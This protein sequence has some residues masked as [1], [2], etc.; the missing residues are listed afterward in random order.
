MNAEIITIG[1]ELLLG[2]VI[3]TNSA[4]MGLQLADIGIS[5]DRR[6]AIGDSESA[7][8]SAIAEARTRC[9]LILLTGGL[10][11][12]RDDI[13]KKTLCTYFNCGLR[14]DEEVMRHLEAIFEKRGRRMLEIN[15]QQADMPEKCTTLFNAV[16]TAPGMRFEEGEFTLIS[17]PGVPSEMMHILSTHVF[18]WLPE[19]YELPAIVH[20]TLLTAGIPESLLSEKLTTVE[21]QLPVNFKLAYLPA[22]NSIRLRL[23]GIGK[24]KD[25]VEKELLPILETIKSICA[26]NLVADYDTDMAGALAQK[27]LQ[28]NTTISLAESCT[29]GYIANAL[30]KQSGI[31]AVMKGAIVSYSN[32]IKHNELGVPQEI[33]TTEGAVSESCAKAMVEGILRKFDTDVA[34]STT[35]IAGPGGATEDKPV[36]LVFIGV[37]NKHQTIVKRFVFNGNREQ[38]MQRTCTAALQML[39]QLL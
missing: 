12:T 23:T 3:D 24:S 32:E 1:D 34:I 15:M 2:Q 20:K 26:E 6:T 37:A 17:V 35:G 13:T 11:P 38:F 29:G 10:G 18:G 25:L 39:L 33:F 30:I 7:I 31:S 36:G 19:K 14:R 16:G 27:L 22:F 4:W 9:N 28:R 5:V 8:I 21:D